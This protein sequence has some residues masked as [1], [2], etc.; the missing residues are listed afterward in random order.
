[1]FGELRSA[2]R[3]RDPARLRAVLEVACDRDPVRYDAEWIPY[4][5]REE[6]PLFTRAWKDASLLRLLPAEHTIGLSAVHRALAWFNDPDTVRAIVR[7]EPRMRFRRAS[8]RLFHAR[9]ALHLER[10]GWSTPTAS[11]FDY[12]EE[13]R[14]QAMERSS[15]R[16]GDTFKSRAEWM[17]VFGVYEDKY[18]A[19]FCQSAG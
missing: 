4:L 17:M 16:R 6:L 19:Q 9:L 11:P 10:G 5:S 14:R 13:V 12:L 8:E 1:M 7:A 3:E 15:N 2:L 18:I